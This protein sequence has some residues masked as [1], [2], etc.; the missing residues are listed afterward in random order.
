MENHSGK[1]VNL[2]EKATRLCKVFPPEQWLRDPFLLLKKTLK[3]G[4]RVGVAC[5]GGA[6]STFSLLMLFS[7]FAE[8]RKNMVV[9]HYNHRLRGADSDEDEAFVR[10]LANEL[11]LPFYSGEP[12]ASSIAK[13]EGS[14][15]RLRLEFWEKASRENEISVLVQGHNLDDLA[16]TMLW[17]IP[18]GVSLDGLIGPRALKR[19]G[20]VTIARPFLRLPRKFIRETLSIHSIYWREDES[21]AQNEYLR[22][23]MRNFVLPIWKDAADRDLLKGVATTVE[24]LAEDSDAMIFHARQSYRQCKEGDGINLKKAL[25]LPAATRRRVLRLWLQDRNLIF[26]SRH[27][28]ASKAESLGNLLGDENFRTMQIDERIFVHIKQ[29]IL[30]M[31]EH[32][33]FPS[34]PLC[35][36]PLDCVLH[37]P[38]RLLAG[39]KR[40]T[41]GPKLKEKI[42]GKKTQPILEAY[43]S[44]NFVEKE[45]LLRSRKAGDVFQPMGA[46]GRKKLSDWMI[47]R[48]WTAKQKSESPVFLTHEGEILWVPGFAPSEHAK[49]R[50]RDSS[51]IRLTCQQVRT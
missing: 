39:A 47:D 20:S 24:L 49:V 16:E 38:C 48:K 15:R 42:F 45:I 36:L 2:P 14:L 17:R 27:S 3:E 5:S 4:S 6:D 37:L 28:L 11:G 44:Q 10:N 32:A 29:G 34:L 7:A 8:F 30:Y 33:F 1:N 35:R 12:S 25:A 18:R 41:M 13:D 51:V 19:I 31:E 21:N 46:P 40:M 22:N 26:S 50:E 9:L 43:L 23:K